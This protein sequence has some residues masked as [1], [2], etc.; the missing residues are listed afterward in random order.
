MINGEGRGLGGRRGGARHRRL[1]QRLLPVD[2]RQGLQRHGDL[3]RVQEGRRLR[4][5]L[6]HAD[7]PHLH[8]PG[9]RLPVEAHADERVAAQRRPG[10]GAQEAGRQP[11]RPAQIP[12]DER[13]YYLERKYPS[14]GNLAPRDIASRAAKQVC[15]EGRGVGPGGRGVFLDFA[16]RIKRLGKPVIAERYGNLFD[17]YTTITGEDPYAVPM[18]IYPARALHDGRAVGGL[19]PDVQRARPARDRRGELHRSRR[20]PPGRFGADAGPGRRLLRA[21]VHHRRTTSRT[22]SSPRSPPITRSSRRPWR[23]PTAA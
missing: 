19:Q 8:S 16:D 11:R 22:P 6:L 15:D 21:A 4:Q 20:Q 12:E 7:P 18:R 23:T 3:A 9:G 10:V 14:F 5:P 13:D 1:R 2:Q 17:M